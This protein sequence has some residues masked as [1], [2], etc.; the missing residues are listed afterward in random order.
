MVFVHGQ[1]KNVTSYFLPL[2]LNTLCI[3][4][5]KIVAKR[6]IRRYNHHLQHNFFRTN[7]VSALV[8]FTGGDLVA[9]TIEHESGTTP[10]STSTVLK[11]STSSWDHM[12]TVKMCCWSIC[13]YTPFFMYYFRFLDKIFPGV[14]GP[15]VGKKV[16]GGF[17]LSPFVN[18][19]YL[20][21]SVVWDEKMSGNED[22]DEI[23]KKV[24]AKNRSDLI[25]TVAA[26]ASMWWP[27]NFINFRFVPASG[28]SIT[29]SIC[30]IFWSCYLSWVGAKG[31]PEKDNER[32]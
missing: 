6:L 9:Q 12:R 17:I 4:M 7:I 25:N 24:H 29:T 2:P 28:R 26:S 30:S 15:A 18:W 20:T 23:G 19:A 31:L 5:A 14:G 16:L 22:W 3:F 11:A 32:E 27:M 10:S 21:F 13:A 1:K 8:I